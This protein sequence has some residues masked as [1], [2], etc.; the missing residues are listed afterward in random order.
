MA[1][2]KEIKKPVFIIGC[3]RSGTTLLL[4]LL[5]AHEAFAWASH[6]TN[7]LSR[8]SILDLL[9]LVYEVPVLGRKLFG[10]KISGI[11]MEK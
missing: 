6:Y 2:T 9:N 10:W 1:N 5:A 11:L 8:F 7:H 3:P 4:D